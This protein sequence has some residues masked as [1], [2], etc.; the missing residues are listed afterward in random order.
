MKNSTIL[1][2]VTKILDAY[3][4]KQDPIRLIKRGGVYCNSIQIRQ[5]TE[6]VVPGMLIKLPN[7]TVSYGGKNKA[8]TWCVA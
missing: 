7:N 3:S 8:I 5:E 6:T 2:E 1:E 4:I